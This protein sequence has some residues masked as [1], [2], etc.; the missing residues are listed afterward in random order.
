MIDDSHMDMIPSMEL[1]WIA[2]S[3][4]AFDESG[5]P[6]NPIPPKG[7]MWMF[8]SAI[9]AIDVTDDGNPEVIWYWERMVPMHNL[10]QPNPGLRSVK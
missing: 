4:R 2:T 5:K 6:M 3:G 10:Q 1:E 9:V 8:K 7:E